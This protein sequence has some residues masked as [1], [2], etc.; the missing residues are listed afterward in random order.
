MIRFYH[1][2]FLRQSLTYAVSDL[3]LHCLPMSHKRETRLIWVSTILVHKIANIFLL[4]HLILC[5]LGSI[6]YVFSLAN[7]K[8]KKKLFKNTIRVSKG[9]DPDQ[10]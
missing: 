5:M 7:F 9:F 8:K 1:V 6:C 10:H 3:G 4:I 2:I